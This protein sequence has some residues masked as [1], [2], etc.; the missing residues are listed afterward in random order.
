MTRRLRA[1][2]PVR[3]QLYVAGDSPA[4]QTALECRHKILQRLRPQIEIEVIDILEDRQAARSAGI[5]A[6]PTLSD[7]TQSPPRRLVGYLG[8]PEDVL[9]HFN[10][11][12]IGVTS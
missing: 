3:L 7:D 6:A 9:D 1:D 2:A 8:T 4:M 11:H 5:L 12:G 10:L